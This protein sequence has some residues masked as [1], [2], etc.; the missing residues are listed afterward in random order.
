MLRKPFSEEELMKA[1]HE[2]A[3]LEPAP[4]PLGR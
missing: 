1:L 4:P 3:G 2:A